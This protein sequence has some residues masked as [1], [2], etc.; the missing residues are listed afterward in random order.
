M[1]EINASNEV[2]KE[3]ETV[4]VPENKPE[5]KTFTQEEV[6]KILSE[7]LG[8]VKSKFADYDD[9][10]TKA[11]EY[12]KAIEEKRLAEL[13]AQ[14]RAEE[15]AK[16]FE[17]ERNDYANQ[18]KEYQAKVERQQIVNQFIKAAPGANIPA[19]RIDAALKLADLSAVTIGED[20]AVNG[21]EDVMSA[22]VEQYGFLA[23]SKKPQKPIGEPSNSHRDTSEK[24]SEQL[25][26]EAAEKAK[27]TQKRED[28][29]A[30]A[31]LK[32]QLG[33]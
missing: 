14:E 21:L 10:K 15:L 1:S 5:V 13:S 29:M 28:F 24:T 22:L 12:E 8:R 26:R 32:V 19:D 17:A 23:E 16:K 4:V 18:L 31:A 7:R 11:S 20:G 9:L 33:K 30:Y 6:D 25:L 27:R 3:Q 2:V